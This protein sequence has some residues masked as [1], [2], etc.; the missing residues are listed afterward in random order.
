MSIFPILYIIN[1]SCQINFVWLTGQRSP[2][3]RVEISINNTWGSICGKDWS[4]DAAD[5]VCRSLGF[6]KA[7]GLIQDGR[8]FGSGSGPIHFDRIDCVG[9]ETNI[10][11]CGFVKENADDYCQIEGYLAAGVACDSGEFINNRCNLFH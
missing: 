6:R 2:E 10:S 4:F 11:Q 1:F 3:G 5:V 7:F 8:T 9:I